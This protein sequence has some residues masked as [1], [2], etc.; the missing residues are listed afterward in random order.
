MNLADAFKGMDGGQAIGNI[1]DSQQIF[2][3]SERAKIPNFILDKIIYSLSDS[4]T[5]TFFI[6]LLPILLSAVVIFFM[7]KERVKVAKR[8]S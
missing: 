3:T 2:E 4:I 1:G 7:G 6:A 5:F 8:E